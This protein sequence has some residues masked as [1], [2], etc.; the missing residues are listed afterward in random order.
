[1][2]EEGY[3]NV[4]TKIFFGKTEHELK[5]LI[6]KVHVLFVDKCPLISVKLVS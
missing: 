2:F 4:L 1:M 6:F 3:Q 5:L